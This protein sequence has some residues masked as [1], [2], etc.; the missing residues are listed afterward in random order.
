MV[1]DL[2]LELSS[3]A[4]EPEQLWIA[5]QKPM[6]KPSWTGN[7]ALDAPRRATVRGRARAG[8]ASLELF[9]THVADHVSLVRAMV[10][11]ESWLTFGG[12]DA[13]LFGA[14][15]DYEGR[16]AELHASWHHGQ[17]LDRRTP[18]AEI[19]PLQGS[20]TLKIPFG[21]WTPWVRFTAADEQDRV[22]TSLNE[23]ATP[24]WHRWD[25]GLRYARRLQITAEV[26]NA[27]DAVYAR[28]LSYLRDPFASGL[29]VY[30]PGRTLRV[31]LGA[32]Y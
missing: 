22:D 3:R 5:V 12:V 15:L 25:A 27:M 24:S 19:E 1:A 2:A 17:N 31:G 23:T 26:E 20:G 7:P 10:D 16:W 28:H 18:L 11:G 21:A 4:P 14:N 8:G 13:R 29:R 6:G 32:V 9:G 30:E